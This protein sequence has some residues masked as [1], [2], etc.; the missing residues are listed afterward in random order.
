MRSRYTQRPS[1]T[2]ILCQRPLPFHARCRNRQDVRAQIRR[3]AVLRKFSQHVFGLPVP[4]V[5]SVSYFKAYGLKHS[6]DAGGDRPQIRRSAG[7]PQYRSCCRTGTVALGA[8]GGTAVCRPGRE[9]RRR[10][11]GMDDGHR[12][13]RRHWLVVRLHPQRPGGRG[14]GIVGAVAAPVVI[15]LIASRS[16]SPLAYRS[17]IIRTPS[18][19]WIP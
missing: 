6:Y 11:A 2:P 3:D 14:T 13:R 8:I 4:E 5:P 17:S 1:P 12:N 9:L 16:A 10:T 18:I 19:S 7:Q 15:I